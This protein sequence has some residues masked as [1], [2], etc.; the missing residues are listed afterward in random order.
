MQ[1]AGF[2][3]SILSILGMFIAFLP[4][5]GWM[6]W[7]VIPFAIL[8]LIFSIVGTAIARENRGL[9]VAGIVLCII[10]IFFG[11]IRLVIGGGIF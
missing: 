6:N 5:L 4:F 2:V 3:I 1:I 8:G 7:G 11:A 9:G 10:A